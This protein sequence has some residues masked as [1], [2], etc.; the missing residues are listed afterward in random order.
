MDKRDVLH[1]RNKILVY[2]LAFANVLA[3][4][5]LLGV[6]I[7]VAQIAIMMS[8]S[9]LMNI[10]IFGLHYSKKFIVG[11]MYLLVLGLMMAN[12][13]IIGTLK[14]PISMYM[15]FLCISI[16]TIYFEIKPLVFII[17]LSLGL[18]NYFG[19]TAGETVFGDYS[20][21]NI[22][23]SNMMF[24]I[25]SAFA[26]IQVN[27]SNAF[28]NNA[29]K[30]LNNAETARLKISSIHQK[31]LGTLGGIERFSG[32]LKENVKKANE[33]SHTVANQFNT[34]T[35]SIVHQDGQ[36]ENMTEQLVSS[37][38]SIEDLE[39]TSKALNQ[40]SNT[41]QDSASAGKVEIDHLNHEIMT[42]ASIMK[43]SEDRMLALRQKTENIGEILTVIGN[44]SAQ[45]NLLALNASIEAARA[46]E[47]GRGF[48]V[49]A[50]EVRKLAEDSHHS[51]EKISS[52]LNEIVKDVHLVSGSIEKGVQ[53]VK[54]TQDQSKKL[55]KTFDSIEEQT[56]QLLSSS[57][58]IQT[59]VI[60]ING[61]MK[62]IDTSA[63]SV[64]TYSHSNS[65]ELIDLKE[66]VKMQEH[67]VHSIG[68]GFQSFVKEIDTLREIIGE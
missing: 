32:E 9:V 20:V 24:I 23:T 62:V 16:V 58:V 17:A 61:G 27:F 48:A 50:D 47:H 65:E 66:T 60:Q 38:R 64:M 42:I 49:V 55:M 31:L 68:E 41:T 4:V 33:L 26:I 52:I 19:I 56:A 46:G 67:Q 29:N 2:F 54:A 44:I 15:L 36:I 6:K 10:V 35:G 12:F 1:Q 3:I 43:E 45:T 7:P 63:K 57:A 22:A 11:T 51:V 30:E 53:D 34:I 13:S 28:F 40:L 59:N 21:R 39:N 25:F 14:T 37:G 18:L 8:P 5:T